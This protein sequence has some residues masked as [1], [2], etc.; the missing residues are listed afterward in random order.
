M[1]VAI[2]FRWQELEATVLELERLRCNACGQ[3]FTAEPPGG[4]GPDQYDATANAMIAQLKYGTGVPFA[5]LERMEKQLG[6]PP[7]AATQWELLEQAAA[8]L[9]PGFDHLLWQA[10]HG[11][12][13]PN[14][15][16]GMRIL[17]LAR[18]PSDQRTGIFTSGIVSLWRNRKITLFFTGRQPAGENLA[19]YGTS[20]QSMVRPS[21]CVMR[22]R[23]IRPR[24][25]TK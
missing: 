1:R 20:D 18:E 15:D 16:I 13:I 8:V 25:R 7:R 11:E 6:V 19:D 2:K 17:C 21:R 24:W 23:G 14:D 9:K 3:V 10:A 12:V 5:R 22:Y 4:I